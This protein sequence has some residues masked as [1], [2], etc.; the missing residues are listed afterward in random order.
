[1][2]FTQEVEALSGQRVNLCFQCSK[3]SS[4]CPMADWMDLKP[5]QVV[6]NIRLGR[7]QVV[8]NSAAIWY[9]VGCETCT[10]RCPQGVEPAALMNA[11]RVLAVRKGIQPR[12]PEVAI[13]YRG[14][15]DNMRLFGRIHDV[16][17]VAITRLLAGHLFDDLP[18]ALQLLKRGRLGAPPL[19][20][21]G[22]SFRRLYGHVQQREKALR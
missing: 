12:I 21:E 16:S 13:Y 20:T 4:S 3:C 8:L 2:S 22:T 15:V 14:F 19:P 1:M 6:H 11:A 9:C 17:L 10:E 7:E 18:L 5:A